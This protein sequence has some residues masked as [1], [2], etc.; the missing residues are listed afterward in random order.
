MI[1]FCIITGSGF[2]DF[3]GASDL[4]D[5]Q[6]QTRYGD[7]HFMEGVYQGQRIAVI[8]RHKQGHA[9]LP[10]MINHRANCAAMAAMKPKAV[11]ATSIC[12]ILNKEI[13]LGKLMIF[14]DL[15]FPDNR[16]PSGDICSMFVDE[17]QAGR[18]HLMFSNPFYDVSELFSP[19][20]ALTG[21][22]Y[23]HVNGPRFNSRKEISF[24]SHYCDAISQTCGPETI[25]CNEL[26]LPYILLGFSVDYANGIME[27]NTPIQELDRNMEKSKG[28]F[29]GAMDL[30]LGSGDEIAY[31]NF[32]YRFVDDA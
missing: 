4:V 16:L 31:S 18:G 17:A 13:P 2:Y 5:R 20:D 9:L 11:I 25:L 3:P 15:F 22:T 26:E 1:D 21:M 6:I 30:I 28:I 24:F 23:G 8:S 27:E 19:K 29:T 12:G 7:V 10:N 14:D 32:V